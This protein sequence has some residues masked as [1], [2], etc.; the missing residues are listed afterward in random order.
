MI[1]QIEDDR[2]TRDDLRD[3][4]IGLSAD[5]RLE[6]FGLLPKSEAEDFF[7]ALPARDMSEVVLGLPPDERRSW[8]RLAP[9]EDV[10]DLIQKSPGE[11]RDPLLRLLDEPTRKE[12][13]GLLAYGE[14]QAGGLMSPRYARVR[15]DMTVDEA[16][17]YLRKQARSNLETIFYIYVIDDQQR[18]VGVVSL[19]QLLSTKPEK[20]VR[21]LMRKDVISVGEHTDQEEVSRL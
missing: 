14:D 10:A 9:P 16:I 1:T 7:L 4:W 3:I 19:K 11:E 8:I 21:E 15:P 13:A 5:E 2:L 20:T 12:V 18:V 17:S 6:G